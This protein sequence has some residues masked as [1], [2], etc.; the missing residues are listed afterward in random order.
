LFSGGLASGG[1]TSS[2]FCTSHGVDS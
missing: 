1:F 2:L